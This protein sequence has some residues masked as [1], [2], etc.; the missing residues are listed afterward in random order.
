MCRL[1]TTH[2][3]QFNANHDRIN[4]LFGKR[5]WSRYLRTEDA[6]KNAA[7]YIV[8]NPMRAGGSAP[9]HEYQWS[10]YA[11]TVGVEYP[12]MTL[13]PN[14]LLS[15][16]GSSPRNALNSYR[17]FCLGVPSPREL[18]EPYPVPGTVTRLQRPSFV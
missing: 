16:F 18:D 8:Q 5:F 15:V 17:E 9:L 11:A 13:A 1:N 3:V 12:R 6:V 7:R 14:E 10:S 2:A 4:H